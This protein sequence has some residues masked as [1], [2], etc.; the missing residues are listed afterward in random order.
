MCCGSTAKVGSRDDP[1][2]IGDPTEGVTRARVTIAIE[3]LRAGDTGWFSGT[4][5][6]GLIA[7]SILVP[8]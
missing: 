6:P 2:V 8:T 5:V 3:G 7:S 1:I 4:S